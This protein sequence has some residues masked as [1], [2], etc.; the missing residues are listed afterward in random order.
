MKRLAGFLLMGG[1]LAAL[2]PM[3][4]TAP[5]KFFSR[6]ERERETDRGLSK[7]VLGYFPSWRKADFDISLIRWQSLTHLAHAFAWP[8]VDGNLVVP[9]DYV[10][11]E[12]VAAAHA[13]GVKVILSLGGWGNGDGFAPMAAD[14]VKRGKFI[15]QVLEFCTANGYD[16][17]DI[18]WEFVEGP[19]QRADFVVFMKEL[20][21]GLRGLDPSLLL[22]MAAP[23][24]DYYGQWI[25]YAAVVP[26]LDF[27]SVMTYDY[28]GEWYDH[29]GPN[30]PLYSCGQDPC[31]S[32]DE[33][34]RYVRSRG[35]PNG[36]LLLGIPFYGRYFE[37]GGFYE[38][39]KV[40]GDYDYSEIV[41]FA[42]SG[43]SS[44]WDSCS[45]VP[46]LRSPEGNTLLS[47]DDPRSVFLKCRYVLDNEAAG[48]MIWELTADAGAGAPRLINVI[49]GAFRF[50][51]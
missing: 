11:P 18:D 47:F 10:Y 19:G 34:Y 31:G 20:S 45:Q 38:P 40:C 37:T 28:H 4:G 23:A 43:W 22:T 51:R 39:F 35:V 13:R 17:V 9:P 41:E 44:H 36:K 14:S 7:T 5:D 2:S 12:L 46:F 29:A 3:A 25:D 50:R 26:N 8:D 27:I 16:G 1:L 15:G 48:V 42:R 21:A 33:S 24:G 6:R 30:A 32:M 49:G